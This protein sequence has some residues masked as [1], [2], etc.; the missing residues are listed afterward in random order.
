MISWMQRHNKYLVITIWIAT[1]AFIGAGAVGWGSADLSAKSSS[2][3]KVGDITISKVKYSFT[4]A[5]LYNQY[6]QKFG[7]KFDK[8]VAKKLN[9]ERQAY[10]SLVQQALFLNLAKEFG[11]VASDEEVAKEIAKVDFF[12]NKDGSFNK[13]AYESFL[14]SRGMRASDFEEIIRD[15][16][17]VKKLFNLLDVNPFDFEKEVIATTFKIADKVKYS[18]LRAKDINVTATEDEVK[19]YWEQNKINYLTPKKY[20][21]A[22]L[23]TKDNNLTFSD[24]ELKKSYEQNSFNYVDSNGTTKSFEEVKEQVKRDLTLEKLKKQA[25]IQR[26]RFKKGKIK[27]SE[28]V[29]LAQDDKK[30]PAKVWKAIKEAKEGD[31]IKPKAVGSSYVTINVR[32]VI[33]PQQ[34]SYE[35]AKELAKKDL[36]LKKQKEMLDKKAQEL[37]KEPNKLELTSKDFISLSK[38]TTLDGL[39]PQESLA[40]IRAIFGKSKKVGVAKIKDAVIVYEIVEQKLIDA[41]TP[42]TLNKEI[43]DIKS[44]ELTANLIDNLSK[45][46]QVESYIKGF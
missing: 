38:F 1:I 7:P 22:L 46:Y 41:A 45:K 4:Y 10:D 40:F 44:N 14:K 32:K 12:K 30:F 9:L 11:I 29:T 23:W 42:L 37:A 24:S 8:E 17:I 27:E 36:L 2:V 31:F 19:K 21:L 25:A 15:D 26:S 43:K 16:L 5:N 13:A 28:V 3:A 34:M 35:E 20:E 6:A 39:T 18:I 33:E